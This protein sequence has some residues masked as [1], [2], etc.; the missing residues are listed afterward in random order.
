MNWTLNSSLTESADRQSSVNGSC[1]VL[2]ATPSSV[3]SV[4]SA[5]PTTIS[6]VINVAPITFTN[7]ASCASK[8]DQHS[9]EIGRIDLHFKCKPEPPTNGS[10]I[11]NGFYSSEKQLKHSNGYRIE[12]NTI[13][14]KSSGQCRSNGEHDTNIPTPSSECKLNNG[15]TKK[16]IIKKEQTKENN[17][18]DCAVS[19]TKMCSSQTQTDENVRINEDV[20]T[21]TKHMR[22]VS[23]TS[24]AALTQNGGEAACNGDHSKSNKG[25]SGCSRCKRKQM[26]N[27]RVQCKMDQYLSARL[28]Q[29][30]KDL[31][32]SLRMPRLPLPSDELS[33][34]RFGRYF[35]V[36]EHPNGGGKVLRLYWDEICYLPLSDRDSLAT[37]FLKESF[38]EQ[39]H[40]IAKYVISVVHNAAFPIPDLLEYMA[41]THSSM[42][43]KTG[44]LGH[45]ESDIETTTIASYRE[46]VGRSYSE[47]TFRA[48]PLHQVSLVGV[49]HEEVG[50]YFP[51]KWL[52]LVHSF[53]VIISYQ[54]IIVPDILSRRCY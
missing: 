26:S 13:N 5:S 41:K 33:H 39:P 21:A 48:G 15:H 32:L 17:G 34:L 40:G 37:E 29:M 42:T 23:S 43:V 3:S 4:T 18:V 47:G 25:K 22:A 36:D 8:Y 11:G 24:D 1:V 54:L 7:G 12:S 10:T 9:N 2:A 45:S 27:V 16:T 52:G 51:G 38:R 35:K 49:A 6:T 53:T 20:A 14:G 28:N 44:L 19:V 30:Q 50:G 31:S 46:Q